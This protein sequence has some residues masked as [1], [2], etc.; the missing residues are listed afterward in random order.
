MKIGIDARTICGRK[1]GDRSYTL[2]LIGGLAQVNQALGNPHEFVLYFDDEPPAD[3][4]CAVG[5]ELMAGWSVRVVRARFAR[6]WTLSALPRAARADALD[7]LHVQ[8]NAPRLRKPAVVTTVHDITFRLYPDWFTLKDRLVLGW[9]L[10]AT[11]RTA[12]GTLAVSECT[13]R[14]LEQVYGLAPERITVT[15]NALANGF[16]PPTKEATEET[17]ARLGV[18]RPYA[19]FVGVLQPRKNIERMV[20]ATIAAREEHGLDLR[21]VVAGKV[22]WKAESALETVLAAEVAGT[23]QYL[24]YVDDE[25][26]PALYAGA[27]ML[28]FPTLYEGFGIPVLEAFACGTPVITSNVSA[29]PEVAGDAALLVDPRDEAAIASA[30][31][32]LT[33]D[34][35]LRTRLIARGHER[36][37]RFSWTRTARLTLEAYE[38]AVSMT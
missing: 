19:L 3:L 33:R 8:Y 7:V 34:E 26:L 17:L 13:R 35:D 36:V 5:G 37:E 30:I 18:Q 11:L 32:N 1:T 4:P 2:G 25:D 27:E 31:A 24:G 20:R 14:D 21:L 38:R 6:M 22:G 23:A 29:L 15:P 9:G 12:A 10:R 28:L 16:A